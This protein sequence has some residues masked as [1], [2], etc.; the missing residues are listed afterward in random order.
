VRLE[1]ESGGHEFRGTCLV[2]QHIRLGGR[3]LISSLQLVHVREVLGIP[4]GIAARVSVI[5]TLMLGRPVEVAMEVELLT[6][7]V[8][9]HV[10]AVPLH[11][12]NG[13][14]DT[15]NTSGCRFLANTDRVSETPAENLTIGVVIRGIR[16]G[17]V[18]DVE[19]TDLGVTG[20]DILCIGVLVGV[21]AAR[22][23]KKSGFLPREEEGT[24][25]VI[26]VVHVG[27]ERFA[28]LANT[29]S[30]GIIRP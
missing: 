23:D 17:Y 22:N 12:V 8:L 25:G 28:V 24:G 2:I 14:L 30:I 18:A 4:D 3:E 16:V 7:V 26:R 19:G 11:I 27:D 10:D 15:P 13:V 20:L 1:C 6:R 5:A 29:H 9:V 21:A